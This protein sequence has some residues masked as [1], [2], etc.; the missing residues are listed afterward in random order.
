VVGY[1]NSSSGNWFNWERN[2]SSMPI[3]A[4]VPA[5]RQGT[6]CRRMRMTITTSS[7]PSS[8]SVMAESTIDAA[9][10]LERRRR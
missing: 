5:T 10:F 7:P 9:V 2:V 6:S 8:A 1:S 3:A 4:T